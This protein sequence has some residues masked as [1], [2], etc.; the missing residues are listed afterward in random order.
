[1]SDEY[2]YDAGEDIYEPKKLKAVIDAFH[3]FGLPA[4]TK[5]DQD[6]ILSQ[7]V[8]KNVDKDAKKRVR[9]PPCIPRH[10]RSQ[11]LT[12]FRAAQVVARS[13]PAAQ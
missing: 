10:S 3:Y 7:E 9:T 11:S 6:K 8:W 12:F 2:D 4:D 1:M 13:P 5:E